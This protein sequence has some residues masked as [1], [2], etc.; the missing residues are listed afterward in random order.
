MVSD[1]FL[2]A[3]LDVSFVRVNAMV[4]GGIG[5]NMVLVRSYTTVGRQPVG[6]LIK[7]KRFEEVSSEVLFRATASARSR[8][9]SPPNPTG[10]D[11]SLD[12]PSCR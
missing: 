12:C 1:P 2:A 11:D 9:R 3:E 7:V 6:K 10:G 8:Q 4:L 5:D